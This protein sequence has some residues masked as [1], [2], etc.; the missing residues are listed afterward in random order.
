[1]PAVVRFAAHGPA[2]VLTVA[3]APLPQP[4]PRQVRIRVRAAGVNP[5][6]WKI[7]AGL[8][9]A[10]F[11]VELPH[12]PGQDVAGVVDAVGT[13]VTEWAVGDPVFGMGTATYAEYALAGADRLA[14]K[15]DTLPWDLAGALPTAADAAFRAL[16]EVKAQAGDT[17]LVHAAAGGVGTFALQFARAE[18]IR[19][20]G[21]AGDANHAYVRGLGAEPVVYGAGLADRV[22]ALAPSGVDAAVDLVGGGVVGVSVALT[23]DPARVVSIVDPADAGAHGVR[24]SSGHDGEDYLRQA[25]ERAAELHAEG[26]LTVPLAGVYPL[27]DAAAAHRASETGHVRGKLV[28]TAA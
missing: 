4:G 28:L 23:G 17:V 15:P 24:F 2:D 11:P 10:V 6:D 3:D 27:A 5:L 19:V 14:R 9:A 12:V 1:M 20:I 26:R 13:D 8:L 7:R 16:A 22:R 25:L 18:G 21:T